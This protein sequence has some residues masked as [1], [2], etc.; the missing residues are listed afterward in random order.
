MH[1]QNLSDT[2]SKY[3]HFSRL[4]LYHPM[5]NQHF[6]LSRHQQELLNLS[7]DF[8]SWLTQH[9]LYIA[10]RITILKY[11]SSPNQNPPMVLHNIYNK[12][13][14]CK[15]LSYLVH[16]YFSDFIPYNISTYS[17]PATLHFLLVLERKHLTPSGLLHFL[18]PFPYTTPLSDSMLCSERICWPSKSGSSQNQEGLY[19]I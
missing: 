16:G 9:I 7:P 2:P 12:I 6:L 19:M 14:V 1:P 10:A 15:C 3:I 17:V 13:E 11:E 8:H 18:L 4:S 5:R